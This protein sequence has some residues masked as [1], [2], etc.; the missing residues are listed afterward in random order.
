MWLKTDTSEDHLVKPAT[1]EEK[2][3]SV[4][5]T[6]SSLMPRSQT[7]R[8]WLAVGHE[9][10]KEAASVGRCVGDGILLRVPASVHAR[11]LIALVDS[12]ASRCYMSPNTATQCDL[13]LE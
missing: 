4:S 2:E 12:G 6:D 13:K 5:P 1:E 9:M 7:E 3:F 11:Q 8:H 10:T